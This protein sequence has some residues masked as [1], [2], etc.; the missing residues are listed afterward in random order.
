MN[1]KIRAEL[2]Y[3][4]ALDGQHMVGCR[5]RGAWT[6]ESEQWNRISGNAL[7]AVLG[8]QESVLTPQGGFDFYVKDTHL[9]QFRGGE[10]KDYWIEDF[11]DA[12]ALVTACEPYDDGLILSRDIIVLQEN[13]GDIQVH[14]VGVPPS[15]NAGRRA[16]RIMAELTADPPSRIPK[17]GPRAAHVCRFCPVKQRCDATDKLRGEIQ[18]WSP[19]Y[20]TP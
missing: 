19:N 14:S 4:L 9:L 8:T 10:W 18:D 20:P 1:S 2:F 15:M 13:K 12:W 5:R 6:E 16:E 11:F 3:A 17:S 7:L